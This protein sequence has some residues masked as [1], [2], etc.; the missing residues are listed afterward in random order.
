MS[1]V[2]KKQIFFW[3]IDHSGIG[4]KQQFLE[5]WSTRVA[6]SCAWTDKITA[7]CVRLWPTYTS[8][9]FPV[10]HSCIIPEWWHC[11]MRARDRARCVSSSPSLNS[12]LPVPQ[13]PVELLHSYQLLHITHDYSKLLFNVFG[14]LIAYML[15]SVHRWLTFSCV[16]VWVGACSPCGRQRV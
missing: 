12:A 2:E 9:L 15:V 3:F 7:E 11:I 10:S 1:V 5:C 6:M 8:R 13:W 16:C 4:T 14:P